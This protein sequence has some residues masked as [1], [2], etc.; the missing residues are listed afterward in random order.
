MAN[1]AD[2][3]GKHDDAAKM[4]ARALNYKNLFNPATG[5]MQPRASDGTWQTP[6]TPTQQDGYVEGTAWE[7]LW[8]APQDVSGLIGLLGGDEAF[9]TKLDEFFNDNHYDPYNEPDLQAPFLYDYSGAPWKSQDRV[10]KVLA[11]VYKTTPNGI[12][13]N[14]D[15]GT[16]SSWFIFSSMGF[17]PVD[18]GVP[19]FEMVSPIWNRV[20][21][22]LPAPHPGREF[23]VESQGGGYVQSAALNGV[24]LP[25]PCFQESALLKG[26][27]LKILQSSEPNKTWG[28]A[29]GDRP[30]SIGQAGNQPEKP[31][32]G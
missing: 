7:Y 14:D 3:F 32:A 31:A 5:F 23:V 25:G 20:T 10:R 11:E 26:G 17:Y 30:P 16:M 18:P 13:G 1:L 24:N 2:A 19:T 8:L 28:A 15:C 12:P 22:H 29:P 6:F 4:R 27:R 21:I 9:N